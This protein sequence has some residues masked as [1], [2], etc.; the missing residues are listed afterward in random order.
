MGISIY[1]YM[2]ECVYKCGVCCH[3]L[4]T[5]N[6]QST[7]TVGYRRTHTA[8]ECWKP[9]YTTLTNK[10]SKIFPFTQSMYTHYTV[11]WCKASYTATVKQILPSKEKKELLRSTLSRHWV[12]CGVFTLLM[13]ETTLDCVNMLLSLLSGPAPICTHA[14][15][16]FPWTKHAHEDERDSKPQA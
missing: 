9:L 2:C 13:G 16:S 7:G 11:T 10:H 14:Q 4:R 1:M 6:A 5:N 12:L 8:I 15:K 3:V